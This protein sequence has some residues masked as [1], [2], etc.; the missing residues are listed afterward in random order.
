VSKKDDKKK[1]LIKDLKIGEVSLCGQGANPPAFVT[2][3]KS[4]DPEVVCKQ[5]FNDVMQQHAV[6]DE[7][8]AILNQ[9]WDMADAL[10]DSFHSI[11]MNPAVQDKKNKMMDSFN[12]YISAMTATITNTDVIKEIQKITK[13]EGDVKPMAKTKEETLT[14]EIDVLKAQ[15]D[16]TAVLLADTLIL[17]GMNDIQKAY[18][19]KL[20]DDAKAVFIKKS[21]VEMDEEIAKK[22]ENEET[23]TTT[24]GTVINKSEIGPVVFAVLKQQDIDLRAAEAT[25]AKQKEESDAKDAIAKAEAMFPNLPGTPESKGKILKAIESLPAEEKETVLKMLKSGNETNGKVFKEIGAGGEDISTDSEKLEKLAK[26]K[27]EKD[28]IT[29]AKAYNAVLDTPEGKELY[30]KLNG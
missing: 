26:A 17:A 5:M 29:F 22:A 6:S 10:Y 11:L 2:L 13:T 9:S 12:Q 15:A 24:K 14:E 23:Y 25:I 27:A 19:S 4:E 7:L 16:K 21:S 30:Q 1:H 3:L 28:G 18:H 8:R 20:D